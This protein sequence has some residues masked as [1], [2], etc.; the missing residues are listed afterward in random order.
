M[1]AANPVRGRYDNTLSFA[2]NI[3]LSDAILSRFDILCVIRDRVDPISDEK[4]ADFVVESHRRSHPEYQQDSIP[5]DTDNHNQN[6]NDKNNNNS[7][8]N[9][10]NNNNNLESM[11]Y[12]L[13]SSSQNLNDNNNGSGAAVIS[14]KNGAQSGSHLTFEVAQPLLK[15]YILY[16]KQKIFPRWMNTDGIRKIATLYSELRRESKQVN[17]QFFFFLTNKLLQSKEQKL[18]E[19]FFVGKIFHKSCFERLRD[20]KLSG[21]NETLECNTNRQ[22]DILIGDITSQMHSGMSFRHPQN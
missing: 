12:S 8:N 4:L 10:N 9:N 21:R 19:I 18:V 17:N 15:K 16:A 20:R 14:N 6:Q 2:K 7:N 22:I 5:T 1:A 3:E 13:D 11:N